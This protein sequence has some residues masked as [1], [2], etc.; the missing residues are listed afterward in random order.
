M[1]LVFRKAKIP[2]ETLKHEGKQV[3]DHLVLSD[4]YKLSGRAGTLK[5]HTPPKTSIKTEKGNDDISCHVI[6]ARESKPIK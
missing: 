4:Q 6:L 5:A 1:L 2:K 3:S